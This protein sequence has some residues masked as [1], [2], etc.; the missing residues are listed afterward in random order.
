[1]EKVV[2]IRRDVSL[3]VDNV[4][5]F[6]YPSASEIWPDMMNSLWWEWFYKRGTVVLER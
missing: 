4:V 6:F 5:V 1:M 2:L 3:E